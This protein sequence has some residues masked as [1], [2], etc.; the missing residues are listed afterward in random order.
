MDS[1][2]ER[3]QVKVRGYAGKRHAVT[4]NGALMP[5]T[6][7][8]V[9]GEAVA[10]VRFR[11]WQ[12]ASCLHPLIPVHAPLTFDVVDLWSGRSVGGCTYH[13]AHPAGRNYSTFPVNAAEA[14]ARRGARF[15][16]RGHR[17][18][19]FVPEIVPHHPGTALYA[20]FTAALMRPGH[21]PLEPA[22]RVC[23]HQRVW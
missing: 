14:E 17:P 16:A 23:Y 4:C 22:I 9:A 12:P 3:L 20:R 13:V 15:E 21:S 8:G 19:A 11:A 2:L 6:S 10:G 5:L 7:T 18:G 1:S